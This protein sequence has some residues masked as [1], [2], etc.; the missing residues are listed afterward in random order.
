M[1]LELESGDAPAHARVMAAA[2]GTINA[3]ALLWRI[4]QKGAPPLPLICSAPFTSP[5]IA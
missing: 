2:E 1:L 3:R 4:E 5:T